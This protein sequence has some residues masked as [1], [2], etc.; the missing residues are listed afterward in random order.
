MKLFSGNCG[1]LPDPWA[2]S[3][4]RTKTPLWSHLGVTQWRLCVEVSFIILT[5][6]YW[7]LEVSS[8]SF[9]IR[10][11]VEV[12]MWSRRKETSPWKQSESARYRVSLGRDKIKVSV[13]PQRHHQLLKGRP[14]ETPVILSE[15]GKRWSQ[16]APPWEVFLMTLCGSLRAG[17]PHCSTCWKMKRRKL[18]LIRSKFNMARVH[19]LCPTLPCCRALP[20]K[21]RGQTPT[22]PPPPTVEALSFVLTFQCGRGCETLEKKP[23]F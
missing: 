22:Y 17:R 5:L 1:H 11:H 23:A 15:S 8:V 19:E 2:E 18:T 6:K 21:R 16:E 3:R 7:S 20:F 12:N 10:L 4:Q 9:S 13:C 14:L